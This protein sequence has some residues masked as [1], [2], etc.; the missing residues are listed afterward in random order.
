MRFWKSASMA[1]FADSARS[2]CASPSTLRRIFMPALC[3]SRSSMATSFLVQECANRGGEL[4]GP[5]PCGQMRRFEF[6]VVRA[7]KSRCE[8]AS[9]GRRSR[10]VMPARNHKSWDTDGYDARA[11]I[12]FAQHGAACAVAIGVSGRNHLLNLHHL[13]AMG[14]AVILGEPTGEC[15]LGQGL[16]SG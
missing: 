10:W 15:G 5:F 13:G 16:H 3:R 11:K 9:V 14:L 12:R 1:V 7:G 4:V 6:K 2:T 8:R